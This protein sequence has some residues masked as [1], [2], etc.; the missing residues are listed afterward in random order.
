MKKNVIVYVAFVAS[1]VTASM[2]HAEGRV[3]QRFFHKSSGYDVTV[4]QAPRS[5]RELVG[6]HKTTGDTFKI[7]LTEAGK[8]TGMYRGEAV[9]L[10]MNKYDKLVADTTE[11]ASQ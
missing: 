11:I 1:M 10:K 9:N 8:I 7:Y 6:V 4:L 2:A 5:A 3:L